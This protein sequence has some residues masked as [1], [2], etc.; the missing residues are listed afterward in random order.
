[1]S[2]GGK[3]AGAGRK[4]GVPNVLTADL[5]NTILGALAAVGGQK[6]LEETAVNDRKAFCALL[7]KALPKDLNIGGGLKLQVNLVRSGSRRTDDQ[8]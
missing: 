1:M 5:K 7:G 3:R 2:R 4:R 6:Y 8:L